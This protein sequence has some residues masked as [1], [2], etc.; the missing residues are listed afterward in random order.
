M[1][2]FMLTPEEQAVKKEARDFVNTQVSSRFLRE[3][4]KDEIVYPRDFV[5]QVADRKSVV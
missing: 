1:Y 3:M 5:E 4:D 2:D